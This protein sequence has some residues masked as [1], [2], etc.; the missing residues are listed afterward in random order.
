MAKNLFDLH[1]HITLREG[2]KSRLLI[3][4]GDNHDF[5]VLTR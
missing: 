3:P 1:F 5:Y 4:K 2:A